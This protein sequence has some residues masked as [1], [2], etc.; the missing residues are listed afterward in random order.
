MSLTGV[1]TNELRSVMLLREAADHGLTGVFHSLVG[2]DSGFRSLAGRSSLWEDG[3]QMVGCA[4]SFEIANPTEG[5]GHFFRL[6]MV[7]MG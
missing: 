5:Y 6:F 3:K 2:R 7:R 1:W 4:V